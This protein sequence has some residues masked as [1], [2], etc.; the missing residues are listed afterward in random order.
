MTWIGLDMA[1]PNFVNKIKSAIDHEFKRN[2]Y[3][4]LVF[5]GGGVRGIAYMGA[6]EVLDEYRIVEN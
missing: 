5:K 3:R 6:L 1:L 2:L 4:N